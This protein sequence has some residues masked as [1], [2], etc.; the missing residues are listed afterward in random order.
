M[1]KNRELIFRMSLHQRIR[2]ITSSKADE[3]CAVENY[4]FPVFHLFSNPSLK[5][6]D[7]FVTLFPTDKALAA[8]W[9][10]ELIKNVYECTGNEAKAN[11]EYAYFNITDN[12]SREAISED[13]HLTCQFLSKK[14]CGVQA[15]GAHL[16]FDDCPSTQ[17]IYVLNETVRNIKDGVLSENKVSSLRVYSVDEAEE[18]VKTYKFKG[19]IFGVAENGIDVARYISRGATLIFVDGGASE[20]LE[21]YLVELTE[22]YVK[23]K[24]LFDS[25]EINVAEFDR[26]IRDGEILDA[27]AINQA[28]DRMISLLLSL[29][30][31][32]PSS[33][34]EQRT[35]AS[36]VEHDPVFNEVYHDKLAYRAA[37]QSVVMLKNSGILPLKKD[38]PVAVIGEYATNNDYR[39]TGKN[40]PTALHRPFDEINGYK[41]INAVGYAHGY[42]A[43]QTK[44]LDLIETALGLCDDAKC[45][46][47]YL[48][49]GVGATNL[50]TGQLELLD[51][52]SRKGVKIIAVVSAERAINVSFADKCEAV[53][54]SYNAG[55]G[56]AQAVFDII[57]GEISPSGKLVDTFYKNHESVKLEDGVPAYCSVGAANV[58]YP[59]GFGLSYTRF[60]YK[61]LKLTETFASCTVSNSGSFDGYCTLLL[62]VKRAGSRG[63]LAN[64]VLR[65]Y[66]KVFIKKGDSVKVEFQFADTTF[67]VYDGQND[68]LMVQGGKYEISICDNANAVL[69]TGELDLKERSFEKAVENKLV[70]SSKSG[71]ISFTD[72]EL[73]KFIRREKKKL[74]YG[75]RLFVVIML[76]LYYDA[77]GIGLLVTNLIADKTLLLY[78]VVGVLLFAGNLL[79]LIY[80]IVISKRR[81]LQKYLHPNEVITDMVDNV[82]E[83]EEVAKVTYTKPIE[84]PIVEFDPVDEEEVDEEVVRRY[85][86]TFAEEEEEIEFSQKVSF[87]ELCTSF[88]KYASTKGVSVEI[89]SI[90]SIL[91][92]MA[93]GKIIIISCKNKEALP[94]FLQAMCE[95][96][97]VSGRI[98]ASDE[99]TSQEDL[100]WQK[101]GAEDDYVLSDISNAINSAGKTPDRNCAILL[102]NVSASNLNDYFSAFLDYANFPTEE[103]IIRIS[104]DVSLKMPQNVCFLLVPFS[105]SFPEEITP[106]V[107]HA[108]ITVDIV[109]TKVAPVA[110]EEEIKV[111]SRPALA[112]LVNEAREQF[113]VREAVW[114]KLDEFTEAVNATEKFSIDNKSLLQLEKYTSVLLECGGDESEA[115]INM[116]TAKIVPLL[117]VSKAYKKEAGGKTLFGIIEKLFSEENLSAVKRALIATV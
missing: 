59:F 73:D 10:D 108:S 38:V 47:V 5:S 39:I 66:R 97:A 46:I 34:E 15:S 53:L 63:G 98:T 8:T 65:G 72:T 43:N 52:L 114:K 54:F 55:Q 16:N 64:R 19:L 24:E 2:L 57:S 29:K 41:N 20:G 62:F 14:A 40:S 76:T 1:L 26:R 70:T 50:P 6:A 9:N 42:A 18:L 71:A 112:D 82:K 106:S 17:N 91:A 113:F 87:G 61:N 69:L 95:Y 79:A 116:F 105:D 99:W 93:S 101:G 100:L 81:K 83:F 44:R 25:G 3:N 85:D 27:E 28:C 33:V 56:S 21:D 92:A 96:F 84:K 111:I 90:R 32:G 4:E 60:E 75:F 104:D 86:A 109:A 11:K 117:K 36:R 30:E 12:I 67:R 35:R 78:I 80:I 22:K 110:G 51:A 102:D 7:K 45:A 107:A 89:S 49:A 48:C 88:R 31:C 68:R 115:V 103:H 94:V 23:S 77:M 58:A 37:Q 74:S 13:G